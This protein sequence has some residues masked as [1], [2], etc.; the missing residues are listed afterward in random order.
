LG[1]RYVGH[2]EEADLEKLI[3]TECISISNK[4]Y[5]DSRS[6]L[7]KAMKFVDERDFK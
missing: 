3:E 6:L 7:D 4:L 2:L 1:A 5:E